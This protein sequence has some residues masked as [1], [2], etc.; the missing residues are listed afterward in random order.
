M[1]NTSFALQLWA[2]NFK[3]KEATNDFE[4]DKPSWGLGMGTNTTLVDG[5]GEEKS[6]YNTITAYET[7]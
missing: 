1:L 7:S 4:F 6:V 5:N 3:P 2:K